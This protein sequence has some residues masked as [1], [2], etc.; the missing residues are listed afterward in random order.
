MNAQRALEVLGY[1]SIDL[2]NNKKKREHLKAPESLEYQLGTTGP[3][4]ELLCD[5]ALDLSKVFYF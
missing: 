4:D 3:D 5:S 1:P 2:A